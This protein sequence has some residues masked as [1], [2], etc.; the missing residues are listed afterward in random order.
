M[1][2][3]SVKD[4]IK[5]YEKRIEEE[6]KNVVGDKYPYL[7][8]NLGEKGRTNMKMKSVPEP[9]PTPSRMIVLEESMGYFSEKFVTDRNLQKSLEILKYSGF[10]ASSLGTPA[11]SEPLL[12]FSGD[13]KRTDLVELALS[14]SNS[15]FSP[16]FDE[17]QLSDSTK[18]PAF[19]LSSSDNGSVFEEISEED[20]SKIKQEWKNKKFINNLMKVLEDQLELIKVLKKQEEDRKKEEKERE[21]FIKK[22]REFLKEKEALDRQRLEKESD[23]DTIVCQVGCFGGVFYSTFNLMINPFSNWF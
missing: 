11:E 6:R 16:A 1:N 2:S 3:G 10:L 5:K 22:F 8:R 17:F 19:P 13:F 7:S 12:R 14:G 18:Y 9:H 21:E 20:Y 4:N 23:E 15:A